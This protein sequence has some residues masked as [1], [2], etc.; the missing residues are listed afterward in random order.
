MKFQDDILN[1][2][3]YIRTYIRTSRNQYA[4][5]FFKV[6]GIMTLFLQ[7]LFTKVKHTSHYDV[8]VQ[9]RYDVTGR[10][11]SIWPETL[12][13]LAVTNAG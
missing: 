8:T 5:H 11:L 13:W 6:G 2:N 12:S 9:K 4:P 10:E 7:V 3:T 1:M